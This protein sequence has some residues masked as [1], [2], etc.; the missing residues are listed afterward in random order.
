MLS[1]NNITVLVYSSVGNRQI[2]SLPNCYIWKTAKYNSR[3]IFLFGGYFVFT[4]IL[5]L[6]CNL[7]GYIWC[8]VIF[9]A[10]LYLVRGYIWCVV[11]FQVTNIM[12]DLEVKM[13]Q[14]ILQHLKLREGQE[15]PDV[16]DISL[17]DAFS[18]DLESRY[19]SYRQ[20]WWE[21]V[22]GG[23]GGG[24]GE[25]RRGEVGRGG[26]GANRY[27]GYQPRWCVQYRSRV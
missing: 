2:N 25:G 11:I 9:G 26:P 20:G 23:E 7:V 17:D 5:D 16:M 8:V 4:F 10:W 24:E 14:E 27:D 3:Q 19:D 12:A 1:N 22:G 18:T 21:V 6:V 13:R 15:L